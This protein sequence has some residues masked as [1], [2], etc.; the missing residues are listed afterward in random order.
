MSSKEIFEL[1]SLVHGEDKEIEQLDHEVHSAD[2]A[3]RQ[4]ED[5]LSVEIECYENLSTRS[6]ITSR[7]ISALS[8][9]TD[10]HELRLRQLY[11]ELD[12]ASACGG[13]SAPTTASLS[14]S[15][16]GEVE[17][18]SPAT[19]SDSCTDSSVSTTTAY[20]QVETHGVEP[21]LEQRVARYIID[22]GDLMEDLAAVQRELGELVREA[23]VVAITQERVCDDLMGCRRELGH[24]TEGCSGV[25]QP[26]PVRIEQLNDAVS[27]RR[28]VNQSTNQQLA[29]ASQRQAE[30]G[31]WAEDRRAQVATMA[32]QLALQQRVLAAAADALAEEADC[33]VAGPEATRVMA[34]L[35][36]LTAQELQLEA[37]AAQLAE[38]AHAHAQ[39]AQMRETL[40]REHAT[41]TAKLQQQVSTAGVEVEVA[42][43]CPG[44]DAGAAQVMAHVHSRVVAAAVAGAGQVAAAQQRALE[45]T[46]AIAQSEQDATAVERLSAEAQEALEALPSGSGIAAEL[47]EQ[48]SVYSDRI[49]PEQQRL[50]AVI[51]ELGDMLGQFPPAA[52]GAGRG[53]AQL[54][55]AQGVVEAD[56]AVVM[57]DIARCTE[58]SGDVD[59]DTVKIFRQRRARDL[60]MEVQGRELLAHLWGERAAAVTETECRRREVLDIVTKVLSHSEETE[61]PPVATAKGKK[62]KGRKG[63]KGREVSATAATGAIP[64]DGE[65][66]QE[67]RLLAEATVRLERLVDTNTEEQLALESRLASALVEL[68]EG[69]K[70]VEALAQVRASQLESA[71][72]ARCVYCIVLYCVVLYCVVL[73]VELTPVF[74]SLYS[75]CRVR[76]TSQQ[77]LQAHAQAVAGLERQLRA[78]DEA[79]QTQ[80]RYAEDMFVRTKV[81]TVLYCTVLRGITC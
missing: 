33:A 7:E 11:S 35:S 22:R 51:A 10:C 45:Q 48:A 20:T 44:P 29:V 53:G 42:A 30:R 41:R 60:D 54:V 25:S 61:Q 62:G 70:E 72:D 6:D 38:L 57:A 55:D 49:L 68:Q 50:R 32:R 71:V 78:R 65:R 79:F 36:Q 8:E 73:Y 34:V 27:T 69:E 15:L 21:G 26:L 56:I 64:S 59:G 66:E 19:R 1:R 47:T 12:D 18:E 80:F 31:Q 13:D 4:Q 3:L 81:S 58:N 16:S 17:A 28:K 43:E 75:H 40:D 23:E 9:S 67:R 2:G 37:S 52:P 24:H 5:R 39:Q 77:R 63:V 76:S 14:G 74:G 46:A